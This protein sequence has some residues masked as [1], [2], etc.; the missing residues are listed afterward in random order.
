MERILWEQKMKQIL[1]E[2]EMEQILRE[3]KMKRILREQEMKQILKDEKLK[4][5]DWEYVY[6]DGEFSPWAQATATIDGKAVTVGYL[7]DEQEGGCYA[8]V[9]GS[10]VRD[11][12]F[13][14]HCCEVVEK[15]IG[16]KLTG[17]SYGLWESWAECH[18]LYDGWEDMDE[19]ERFE[20]Y[21]K[22]IVQF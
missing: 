10:D 19:D 16:E 22:A 9:N 1:R 12:D 7:W 18:E 13:C 21:R 2:Q 4:N 20:L 3:Q 8:D 5:A 15:V 17:L 11:R 6:E 14:E